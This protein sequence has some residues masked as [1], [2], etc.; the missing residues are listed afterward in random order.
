MFTRNPRLVVNGASITFSVMSGTDADPY[1]LPTSLVL[2]ASDSLGRN[3]FVFD[4]IL[5]A[6]D[7]YGGNL[8]Q[9]HKTYSFN[10]ARHVQYLLNQFKAGQNLNYGLNLFVPRDDNFYANRALIDLRGKPKLKLTY[11]VVN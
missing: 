1:K 6:P 11:T 10:I 8:D 7:Y 4:Q 5:E 2:A 3:T 9:S